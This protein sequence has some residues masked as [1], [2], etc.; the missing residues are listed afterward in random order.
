MK[1]LLS[2]VGAG[3]AGPAAGAPAAAAGGAA[4]GGD[5]PAAEEKKEEEEERLKRREREKVVWDGHT[6]SKANTLDKFS[7]TVNFDEQ[8]AAIHRS[9]GLGP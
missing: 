2:N 3:G 8:I 7:T 5:A 6:A 4:A 1:E 9:K